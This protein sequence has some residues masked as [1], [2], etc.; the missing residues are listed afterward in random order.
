[1]EF[2]HVLNRGVDKRDVVLDDKDRVRFLHDLFVFNDQQPVLHF[3][4]PERQSGTHVRKLL[5]NIHAFCL[6]S[7]HY[8]LLLSPVVENGIALF[9][10]KLGMGYTKY[11]NER[12]ARSGALWQGKYKRVHI[13]RDAHFLYVPYYVHLNALDIT[14]PEWR[15]GR[16]KD[17]RQAFKSLNTYRWSSHLDYSGVKNFPSITAREFLSP[18]LGTRQ[19]YEKEIITIITSPEMAGQSLSLE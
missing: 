12:Y 13:E 3:K 14:H 2:Y 7:N 15:I 17:V 18:I 9:M 19:E 1:M 6:M 10:K 5:V 11:F 8:H 4:I 16:V